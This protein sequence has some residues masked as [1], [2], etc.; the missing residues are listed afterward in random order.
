MKTLKERKEAALATARKVVKNHPFR[1]RV[2][3]GKHTKPKFKE[4]KNERILEGLLSA[5][6]SKTYISTLDVEM[7]KWSFKQDTNKEVKLIETKFDRL[8]II[9]LQDEQI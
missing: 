6:G 7:F 9:E 5:K 4:V 8:Y 2:T 1:R 3:K